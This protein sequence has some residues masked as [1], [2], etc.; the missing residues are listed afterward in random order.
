MSK[1]LSLAWTSVKRNRLRSCLL[2]FT[3]CSGF[4]IFG[5]LGTLNFSMSG[6]SDQFAQSRLMV[7]SQGGLVDPLP[8]AYQ[9]RLAAI[10]GVASVGHATWFGLHYQE[11]DQDI[12]SFAVDGAMWLQQHPEMEISDT[13]VQRF[14]RSKNG[15]L[16][17]RHIANRFGWQVGDQ[18]PL[19]SIL[20]Q[21]SDGSGFWSF[22]ISGLFET[23][24]ASGGRKYVIAHYDYLNDGRVIWPDTVGSFIVVPQDGVDANQLATRIDDHFLR[25]QQSTFSATDKAFHDDFFKQFGD[26]FFI[27]KSVVLISF[28]SIV[29]VVASTIALMVRQRTRDIGVLKVIGFSGAHVFRMIYTEVFLL[30]SLGTALGLLL[31]FIVNKVMIYYWPI[32]PDINLPPFVLLQ[33]LVIALALAVISG[34]I[35]SYL[36]LRMKPA[37]AFKVHE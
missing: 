22:E 5:V 27:I 33:T 4:L 30:V 19:K 1:A 29:M 14:L 20:F 2:L 9:Q 25:S 16:V 36:A 31:A 26:V 18:V 12:M 37:E 17:N 6:G 3:I 13:A 15:L 32:I 35:P 24:D 7:I 21:P 34:A 11:T 28:L 23:T 10:D 8:I